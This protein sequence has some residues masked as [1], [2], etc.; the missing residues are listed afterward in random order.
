MKILIFKLTSE[1][2]GKCFSFITDIPESFFD[3]DVSMFSSKM[4]NKYNA[5]LDGEGTQFNAKK[6]I[7]SMGFSTG[8]MSDGMILI[9]LNEFRNF[10]LSKGFKAGPPRR[11]FIEYLKRGGGTC[12]KWI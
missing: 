8:D 4:E 3:D 9:L 12:K 5:T 10:F 11:V 6:D 7:W 2:N 1:V